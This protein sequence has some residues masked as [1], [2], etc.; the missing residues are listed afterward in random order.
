MKFPVALAFAAASSAFV[1][2]EP[3]VFEQLEL[4]DKRGDSSSSWTKPHSKDS[5]VSVFKATVDKVTTKFDGFAHA[6][7]DKLSQLF[8]GVVDD[9]ENSHPSEPSNLTIYQLI[10][11]SKYT[12]KFSK[13]VNEYDDIVK[14]LNSTEAN[15]TLFVPVDSAF[16]H[17]PED[18]KPSKEFIEKV[19]L[20]H[21][22]E[23]EYPAG[24]LL[25]TQTVPTVLKEKLLGDKPQRL[26]I[27]VGF[28]GIRINYF[29]K[30]SGGNIHAKNGVIY[31]VDHI[32]VPPP[33]VGREISLFPGIFS[34]LLLA[35]EKTDFVKFI[36][37]IPLVGSTV[38]APTNEAFKKLGPRANAFLFNTEKG[39]GY[40]E[41]LLKYQIVANTTLYTDAIYEAKSSEH[42]HVDLPTLLG[43]THIAIDISK[44][45]L[46]VKAQV[47]GYVPVV[48]RDNVAKNGVIHVVGRVPFPPRKPH[49]HSADAVFDGEIEVDDIITRLSPYVEN[50]QRDSDM[51]EL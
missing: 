25:H 13:I 12:T 21:I 33:Y 19:L 41:A 17:I 10:S 39:R 3:H 51:G 31:G 43:D 44:W 37:N 32:L 11:E 50:P 29:S 45:G 42:Y 7:G 18:K 40:L 6:A 4:E 16:E 27:S 35:Y 24:R 48:Q 8:A 26:R 23:E 9:F 22:A 5:I 46:F 28:G 38:F 1:V 15:Y 49:G 14:L 36:H 30:I 2:P 47:N 34:T 20:Y